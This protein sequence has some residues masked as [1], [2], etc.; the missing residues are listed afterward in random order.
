MTS[1]HL[2]PFILKFLLRWKSNSVCEEILIQTFD[3]NFPT[4]S[5][6]YTELNHQFGKSF[7]VNQNDPLLQV[8]DIVASL[9]T[10]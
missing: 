6:P 7:S 5:N 1:A 9:L 8:L 4:N 3:L 10:E 2:A